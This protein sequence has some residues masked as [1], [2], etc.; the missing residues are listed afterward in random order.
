MK[1]NCNHKWNIISPNLEICIEC[2]I[3][4]FWNEDKQIWEYREPK[5]VKAS[6]DA[7]MRKGD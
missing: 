2:H 7:Q 1:Y 5:Q 3:L 4:R 6:G